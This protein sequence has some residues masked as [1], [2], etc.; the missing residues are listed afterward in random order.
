MDIVLNELVVLGC[1]TP[2]LRVHVGAATALPSV[3]PAERRSLGSDKSTSE[4]TVEAKGMRKENP[5]R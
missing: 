4:T 5:V 3:L 1:Y 2:T